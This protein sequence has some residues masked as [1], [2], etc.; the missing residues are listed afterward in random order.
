MR[1]QGWNRALVTGA[2][3][4]IGEAFAR[5]LAGRN[6]DLVVVARR[7]QLLQA[8]AAELRTEHAVEVEVIVADLATTSGIRT[9]EGRLE[10]ERDPID[11]LVNNAGGSSGTGRGAFSRLDRETLEGQLVLNAL[12]VMRLTHAAVSAM[13]RRGRGDVIQVSGGTAFYPVPH[14]AV[15]S[16]SKAFVNSFSEAI[17]Y[18]LR[19]SGVGVTVVCPGFTRTEGPKRNGFSEDNIPSWWWSDP[20]EVVDVALRRAMGKKG[21]CSPKVVNKFNAAF[22]RHFPGTMMRLSSRMT[23]EDAILR[24]HR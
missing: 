13:T 11:L 2:S 16:A 1:G 24:T 18:E 6:T 3:A 10:D 7:E 20:E 14:G 15:Y 19:G 5:R 21:V 23:S 8:L 4:G 12:S 17:N 22:G 9:V